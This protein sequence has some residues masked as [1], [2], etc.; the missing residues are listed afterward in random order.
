MSDISPA[1]LIRDILVRIDPIGVPVVVGPATDAQQQSGVVSL[2]DAGL[3]VVEDYVAVVWTR[4]QMRC[5]H[6]T[7]IGAE[8]ISRAIQRVLTGRGRTL[9]RQ[10]VV[11]ALGVSTGA[12]DEY[13]V[14]LCR[15]TAGPS[16]HYDSPETWETLLFAEVMLGTVPVTLG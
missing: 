14:H 2:V 15:V 3:P 1:L 5:L 10:D 4:A 7:L 12:Y 6:G 16:M 8:H 11:T 9:A 13:L